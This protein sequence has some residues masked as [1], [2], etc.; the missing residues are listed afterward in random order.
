MIACLGELTGY[1]ALHNILE[2]MNSSEEGKRILEQ[3]PRINTTTVDLEMLKRLPPY[4]FGRVYV[5]FLETNVNLKYKLPCSKAD[6]VF[7]LK[8]FFPPS[9]M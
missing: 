8:N 6:F 4:S 2:T 3:K 1:E 7:L 5:E 9:R